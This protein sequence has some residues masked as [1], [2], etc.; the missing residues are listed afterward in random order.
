MKNYNYNTEF[1]SAIRHTQLGAL[2]LFVLL[3]VYYQSK[4][5]DDKY[6]ST[7]V[8]SRDTIGIVLLCMLIAFFRGFF[9]MG[10]IFY[11]RSGVSVF[12]T[13]TPYVTMIIA[14]VFMAL[15]ELTKEASG[16]NNFINEKQTQLE[17]KSLTDLE[18]IAYD[19]NP[20]I[21]SFAVVCMYTI[22]LVSVYYVIVMFIATWKG[23][24]SGKQD[25][26]KIPSILTN[27]PVLG[28]ALETFII[29]VM[30][31]AYYLLRNAVY[32][33]YDKPQ[34]PYSDLF[35]G[36]TVIVILILQIMCQYTGSMPNAT[37]VK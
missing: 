31:V 29:I 5:Y 4:Y 26:S 27:R 32:D 14:G 30:G 1:N 36:F 25:I 16:F 13:S 19:E 6:A 8:D 11:S 10:V 20:F 34:D 18:F 35:W 17:K 7:L 22:L 15:F 3:S 2:I 9:S 37:P 24:T 21:T 33:W 28:F 12:K 23:F